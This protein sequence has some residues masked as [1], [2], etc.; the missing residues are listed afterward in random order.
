MSCSIH[1]KIEILPTLANKLQINND[2]SKTDVIVLSGKVKESVSNPK[3]LVCDC[4]K[5]DRPISILILELS[6]PTYRAIIH[7]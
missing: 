7:S 1:N 4:F 5:Y 6:L 3:I 2:W